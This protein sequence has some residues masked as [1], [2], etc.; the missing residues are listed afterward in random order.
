MGKDRKYKIDILLLSF[1]NRKEFKQ[2]CSKPNMDLG[3]E[4]L[5]VSDNALIICSEVP[6]SANLERDM[7]NDLIWVPKL[8]LV[9]PKNET[10]IIG[11]DSINKKDV[12]SYIPHEKGNGA[13]VWYEN[14]SIREDLASRLR[15]YVLVPGTAENKTTRRIYTFKDSFVPDVKDKDQTRL[16]INLI[17]GYDILAYSERGNFSMHVRKK[18]CLWAFYLLLNSPIAA[19]FGYD[20]SHSGE[21]GL[22][23]NLS[24]KMVVTKEQSKE[25][26]DTIKKDLESKF[27]MRL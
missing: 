10:F 23:S 11:S 18:D 20:C 3:K 6:V 16:N 27:S 17:S 15:G 5:E 25:A 21:I 8:L 13:S 24:G 22:N 2:K 12:P 4:K 9:F 26:I 14:K 19:N 7:K 1:Y